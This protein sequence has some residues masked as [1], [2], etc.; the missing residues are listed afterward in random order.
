MQL[1]K[2]VP[3]KRFQTIKKVQLSGSKYVIMLQLCRKPNIHFRLKLQI[4]DFLRH[5][6]FYQYDL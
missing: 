2:K 4:F 1:E 5:S 3:Y 6:Y